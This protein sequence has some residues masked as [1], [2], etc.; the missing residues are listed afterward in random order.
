MDPHSLLAPVHRLIADE[1]R[2]QAADRDLLRAFAQQGDNDAFAE[3]LRRHGRM[4]LHLALHLLHHRQ[5]AEDVFQAAFL[6]LIRKAHSLR[7]ESSVA[8]WLHRVAWRLAMRSR[9]GRTAGVS[10]LVERHQPADAGRSPDQEISL[11]EAHV[12]LHQELAGLPERLRLPLILCYLQGQTRD[13]AA[14]WLGWSLG[15]LKRR[16]EQGRKLLH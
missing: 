2:H 4:V 1:R 6:T 15:T 10:R 12:L 7:N 8:A 5:D 9:K 3:L 16:L 14:R 13:E 11:R